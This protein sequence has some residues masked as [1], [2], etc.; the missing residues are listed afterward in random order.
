MILK[1]DIQINLPL[2]DNFKNKMVCN[3]KLEDTYLKIFERAKHYPLGVLEV[4]AKMG[5]QERKY[6]LTY[7]KELKQQIDSCRDYMTEIFGNEIITDIDNL[8][9]KYRKL[10]RLSF[11]K[12]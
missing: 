8:D 11:A 9:I 10:K 3:R 2:I 4:A 12:T 6:R 5:Y 1:V 7:I